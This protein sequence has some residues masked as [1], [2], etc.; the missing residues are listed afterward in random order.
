[1]DMN[2]EDPQDLSQPVNDSPEPQPHEAPETPTAPEAEPKLPKAEEALAEMRRVLRE[3]EKT[4]RP[5]GFT[6]ALRRITGKLLGRQPKAAEEEVAEAPSRLDELQIPEAPPITQPQAGEA[7]ASVEEAPGEQ[8]PAAETESSSFASMLRD[9]LTGA[10]AQKEE[11]QPVVHEE[12]AEQIE[13][14]TPVGQAGPQHSILTAI[15][16]GDQE[17]SEEELSKL[18]QEAL[19]DYQVAPAEEDEGHTS[20]MGRLR[21]SWRYMRPLERR[22]LIGALVIVGLAV[23]G[24]TGFIMIES[25]PTPT[26]APTPTASIVPIPISISLPGGWIFPL[27]TGFVV[28]GKWNPKGA[29]WLSGTE[30]CRWVSLP[31]TVQLEAVLRTLKGNDEI[32]LSMSN[33]DSLAYKVQSIQQVPASQINK[34]AADTPCLLVILSKPDTNDRWVVTAKP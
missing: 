5:T 25:R 31:W 17:V 26:P 18:R 11:L 1:M 4:K 30:V 12:P 13:E 20:L 16:P 28:D 7:A 29:E 23:M 8:L 34:L 14:P 21:R 19:E 15:R 32:K 24:G 10:L 22:L 9:R 33:Y 2:P 6:A 27:N 3:E